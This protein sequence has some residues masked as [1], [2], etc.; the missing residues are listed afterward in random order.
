[1][2]DNKMLEMEESNMDDDNDDDNDDDVQQESKE[3]AE[4]EKEEKKNVEEQQ[5]KEEEE[6]KKKVEQKQEEKKEKEEGNKNH[7]SSAL[8]VQEESS[9]SSSINDQSGRD[10]HHHH[11]HVVTHHS[12]TGSEEKKKDD[13]D[14]DNDNNN[15]NNNNDEKDGAV[16][17]TNSHTA[18]PS[19]L[20]SSSSATATE[21]V[22]ATSSNGTSTGPP[23]TEAITSTASA[24][25]KKSRRRRRKE[26]I[27]ATS[28]EEHIALAKN[29]SFDQ[30]LMEK[31]RTDIRDM[32][33]QVMEQVNVST[34][35]LSSS[36]SS[37]S[38]STGKT[39]PTV[40]CYILSTSAYNNRNRIIK[41]TWGNRCDGFFVASN[42]TNPEINAVAIPTTMPHSYKYL[43]DKQR[44]TIRYLY[45]N[46]IAQQ[47]D[48]VVKADTDSFIVVENLKQH[49]SLVSS[50]SS[51]NNVSS[52]SGNEDYSMVVGLV[53]KSKT[54]ID[55]FNLTQNYKKLMETVP[56]KSRWRWAQGGGKLVDKHTLCWFSS[57]R[58]GLSFSCSTRLVLP[59]HPPPFTELFILTF[60]SSCSFSLFL[61][62]SLSLLRL[63][64]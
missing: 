5:D 19:P 49:L 51:S 52:S 21:G 17:N 22:N 56:A 42:K 38:S 59:M 45:N 8:N 39:T 33:I 61:S 29:C 37:A 10:T 1:M 9:S 28:L 46:N 31:K 35:F 3:K 15:N 58:L 24:N 4:E 54:V 48:W 2:L 64:K 18:P 47:Y 44:E 34:R 41:E 20:S 62:L 13:D 23:T 11:H 55:D 6:E 16:P 32:A 63:R 50:S 40:L 25:S 30:M 53:A 26:P 36:S 57:R 14:N 43:W 12:G 60:L 27:P 7:A